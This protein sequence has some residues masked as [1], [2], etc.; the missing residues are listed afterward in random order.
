MPGEM[1][2]DYSALDI[3]RA[4]GGKI[5]EERYGLSLVE[6]LFRRENGCD[7]HKQ[8]GKKE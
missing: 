8:S 6:R 1:P 4:A 7:K 3:G 5:D 2:R